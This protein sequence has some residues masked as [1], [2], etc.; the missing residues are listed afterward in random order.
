MQPTKERNNMELVSRWIV[1]AFQ[2]LRG[3][4]NES[5]SLVVLLFRRQNFSSM[6]GR[7][8][9][10]TPFTLTLLSQTPVSAC[11]ASNDFVWES[12]TEETAEQQ[13]QKTN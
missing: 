7:M 11:H 1:K 4:G 8:V 6:A 12:S 10:S 9:E 3:K 13:E 2:S 5:S